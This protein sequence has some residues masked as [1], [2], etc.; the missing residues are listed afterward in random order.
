MK[1]SWK[2]CWNLGQRSL[3]EDVGVL[4]W[5]LGDDSEAEKGDGSMIA[6]LGA[7]GMGWNCRF[8][9]GG[10]A[11][12]VTGDGGNGGG[13][14]ARE[15]EKPARLSYSCKVKSQTSK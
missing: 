15:E 9:D 4:S 1:C 13:K 8:V 10:G 12:L 5:G 14:A 7:D 6:G 2:A 3:T 11:E